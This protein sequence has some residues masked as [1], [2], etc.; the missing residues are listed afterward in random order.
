MTISLEVEERILQVLETNMILVEPYIPDALKGIM[1][2]NLETQQAL[3]NYLQDIRINFLKYPKIKIFGER[4]NEHLLSVKDD[5]IYIE[6]KIDGA[7]FRFYIKNGAVI[8]GSRTQEYLHSSDAEK[9]F[10]RAIDQV[11]KL[12]TES[13]LK[14]YEGHVF[15]IEN[16]VPHSLIY[17][18]SKIPV[19]LGIDIMNPKHLIV[20]Y[21]T[22]VKI[23]NDLKM[24]IVPLV[25]TILAGEIKESDFEN[26]NIVPMSQFVDKKAEGIVLKNYKRQIFAKYVADQFREVHKETFGIRKR[27]AEND[28][29]LFTSI[30]ATNARI[31]KW[32]LKLLDQGN[33][34][35]RKLMHKLPRTVI[36]DIAQEESANFMFKHW[37]LGLPKLRTLI[38]R[39]CLNV[40]DLMIRQQEFVDEI[41]EE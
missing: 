18:K 16:C 40:L 36:T 29:E 27:F 34:L 9:I 33:A 17:N 26:D 32:I 7:N 22:K 20:D 39:R 3:V 38:S 41:K 5:V 10:V 8:Y 21:E 14:K 12:V 4:D 1:G 6:E 2:A 28:N 19:V 30:Y 37:T 15:Y 31:D 11:T 13:F 35:D 23:F 25:K 24:E